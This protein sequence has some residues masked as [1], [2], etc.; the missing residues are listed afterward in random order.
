MVVPLAEE[1][2]LDGASFRLRIIPLFGLWWIAGAC[3]IAAA[4]AGA[5]AR[6]E[7]AP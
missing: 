5:M 6:E 1:P 7:D 4:A 2:R 3:F